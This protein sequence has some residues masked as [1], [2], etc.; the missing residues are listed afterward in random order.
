MR[1][2]PCNRWKCRYYIEECTHSDNCEHENDGALIFPYGVALYTCIKCNDYY[3]FDEDKRV[4]SAREYDR[5]RS[6]CEAQMTE[7]ERRISNARLEIEIASREDDEEGFFFWQMHLL[8]LLSIK[9]KT[10]D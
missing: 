1:K 3:K 7:L 2:S 5:R 8:K 10:N 6:D 4:I 9:E